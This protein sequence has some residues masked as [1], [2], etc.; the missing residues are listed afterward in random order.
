MRALYASAMLCSL[1]LGFLPPTGAEGADEAGGIEEEREKRTLPY[2]G[3]WSSD[4][5]GWFEEMRARAA[6]EGMEDLARTF[7]A[8]FPIGN[9]LGYDH[10]EPVPEP[11]E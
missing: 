6:Y 10:P 1:L 5:F 9:G 8:H 4:F 3:M 7:W 2:W 11:E